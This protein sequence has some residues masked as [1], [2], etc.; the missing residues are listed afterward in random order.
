MRHVI[1]SMLTFAFSNYHSVPC[2]K[3]RLIDSSAHQNDWKSLVTGQCYA[4]TAT[5]CLILYQAASTLY[6]YI[7]PYSPASSHQLLLFFICSYFIDSP[8]GQD[9]TGSPARQFSCSLKMMKYERKN[10]FIRCDSLIRKIRSKFQLQNLIPCFLSHDCN[11][12][13]GLHSYFLSLIT[14]LHSETTLHIAIQ[15]LKFTIY[16]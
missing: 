11:D 15:N 4:S 5:S 7:I 12:S 10:H 9:W 3:W 14:R 13:L 1:H 16:K 6:Y 2:L 8:T